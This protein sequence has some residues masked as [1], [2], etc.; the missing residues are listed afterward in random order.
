[1]GMNLGL[2][3]R[4]RV[5]RFG[6]RLDAWFIMVPKSLLPTRVQS[7]DAVKPQYFVGTNKKVVAAP[8]KGILKCKSL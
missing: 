5:L 1:M 2:N 7:A 3:P 8:H 4:F 6:L